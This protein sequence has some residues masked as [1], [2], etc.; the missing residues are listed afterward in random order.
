MDRKKWR[1]P[2][3]DKKIIGTTQPIKRKRPKWGR[4]WLCFCGSDKKYK[5][6]CLKAINDIALMNEE[7]DI[8]SILELMYKQR[9]GEYNAE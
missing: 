2:N 1:Q 8:D 3:T 5:H 9:L 4:N 6:C 7:I